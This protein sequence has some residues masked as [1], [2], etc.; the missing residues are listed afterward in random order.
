MLYSQTTIILYAG[1]SQQVY[2]TKDF[3]T[4]QQYYL[5]TTVHATFSPK[6][7]HL[8]TESA[9]TKSMSTNVITE[10]GSLISGKNVSDNMN[11]S[12]TSVRESVAWTV[13]AV[14]MALF[15]VSLTVN[16]TMLW[17]RYR[18]RQAKDNNVEAPMY[19]IESNPCYEAASMK[20]TIDSTGVQEVH[21]YERVTQNKIK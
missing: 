18:K 5:T 4:T 16:I 20:Q 2:A 1:A 11:L 7:R 13:A 19:E 3:V 9:V 21:L 6:G 14:S 10:M 8:T 12:L 17:L 15:V